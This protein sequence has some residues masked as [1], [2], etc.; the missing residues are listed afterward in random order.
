MWRA[1]QKKSKSVGFAFQRE[2]TGAPGSTHL[3][4]VISCKYRCIP[5]QKKIRGESR[6]GSRRSS[7]KETF[8]N[9]WDMSHVSPTSEGSIF[10]T[11]TSNHLVFFSYIDLYSVEI[12]FSRPSD[13]L[14]EQQIHWS[15]ILIKA[16]FLCEIICR[17]APDLETPK[18]RQRCKFMYVLDKVG[19]CFRFGLTEIVVLDS[20]FCETHF[21]REKVSENCKMQF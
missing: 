6:S 14:V 3:R 2:T 17:F 21:Y 15:P 10:V 8:G 9:K 19:F 11:S 13:H 5:D 1:L 4:N 16:D 12:T 18:I 20:Y 7:P